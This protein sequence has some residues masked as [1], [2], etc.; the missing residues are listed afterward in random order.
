MQAGPLRR[1]GH[2]GGMGAEPSRSTS[3][4]TASNREAPIGVVIGP[5]APGTS[6]WAAGRTPGGCGWAKCT[7][8]DLVLVGPDE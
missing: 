6:L 1:G 2:A 3:L 8:D 7:Q 4:A 5:V